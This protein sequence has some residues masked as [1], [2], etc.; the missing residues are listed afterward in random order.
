M[1]MAQQH[2]TTGRRPGGGRAGGSRCDHR[3]HHRGR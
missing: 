3:R 2:N 1:V